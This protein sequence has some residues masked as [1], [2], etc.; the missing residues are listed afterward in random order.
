MLDKLNVNM[1]QYKMRATACLITYNEEETLPYCLVFLNSLKNIDEICIVDSYSTDN[2]L[3]IIEAFILISNKRVIFRTRKFD[4]FCNQRNYCISLA[5][6]SVILGI[7]ADETYSQ[8]IDEVLAHVIMDKNITAVRLPTI[9]L[10]NNRRTY[11]VNSNLDP[12]IRIW[13]KSRC[14]YVREAHEYLESTDGRNLHECRDSDVIDYNVFLKHAQLLKTLKS[15]YEKGKRWQ[16][17]NLIELSGKFGIP[18]YPNYWVDNKQKEYKSMKL[19]LH[20]Y[21]ITSLLEM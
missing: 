14:R 17:L 12:H 19:P 16:E 6:N 1:L 13:R 10:I 3:Q 8:S 5:S 21:D 2:T 9:T 11:I 20:L 7:D 15:L 18:I 4:N